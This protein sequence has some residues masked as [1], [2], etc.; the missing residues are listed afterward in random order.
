MELKKW[1]GRQF[2]EKQKQLKATLQKE[3]MLKWESAKKLVMTRL[4]ILNEELSLESG[5]KIVHHISGRIKTSES[6][7]TKLKKKGYNVSPEEA[8]ELINDIVGVR[9]VCLFE[10]D[11]Y[12]ILDALLFSQEIRIV[13][14]KDYIQNPKNSGYRS[15][16][17]IV[18]IPI[19]FSKKQQWVTVEIQLRTTAMDYWAELDYQFR[20]KKAEKKADVIGEELKNYSLLIEELDQKM[21][22]LRNQISAI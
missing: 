9:A 20:Y 12:R 14:I 13:K 4:E 17:V 16:H 6:L 15:L 11:L 2:M 3:Q 10:D 21:M 18:K 19:M 22:T 5:R 7:K 1:L 8:G